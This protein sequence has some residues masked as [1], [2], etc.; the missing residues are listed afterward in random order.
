MR[1]LPQG[2]VVHRRRAV[3]T[4]TREHDEGLWGGL[5]MGHPATEKQ[6]VLT[7]T[8][9]SFALQGTD[10][11]HASNFSRDLA[12]HRGSSEPPVARLI[13]VKY[14]GELGG[15][16]R[17]FLSSP[18]RGSSRSS[19]RVGRPRS[20]H[21]D[22]GDGSYTAAVEVTGC[23]YDGSDGPFARGR[24]ASFGPS[25]PTSSDYGPCSR[26]DVASPI[27]AA[28]PPVMGGGGYR[29]PHGC[30]VWTLL[31]QGA[32]HSSERS[33]HHIAFASSRPGS[34][35][36][37]PSLG[38]LPRQLVRRGRLGRH[39]HA[40]DAGFGGASSGGPRGGTPT[41]HAGRSRV[42]LSRPR[43]V[44]RMRI[45]PTVMGVLAEKPHRAPACWLPAGKGRGSP[46][47]KVR[48]ADHVVAAPSFPRFSPF[49][50]PTGTVRET[51]SRP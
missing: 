38:C 15:V 29:R 9:A 12:S 35:S 1:R 47:T 37:S 43:S 31:V 32:N 30:V 2:T 45:R 14:T 39:A 24:C 13:P 44:G 3:D 8:I 42:Q 48:E 34:R 27:G 11:G 40:R 46:G 49:P 4:P 18:P 19:N 10:V 41:P 33:A 6:N 22:G 21:V 5:G 7:G 23:G 28:R 51:V 17:P 50:S 36:A 20:L 26:P 25:G 16:T